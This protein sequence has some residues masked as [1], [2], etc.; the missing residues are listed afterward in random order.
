M[1]TAVRNKKFRIC[2]GYLKIKNSRV[3]SDTT[4]TQYFFQAT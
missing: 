1:M 4:M 3:K 2:L